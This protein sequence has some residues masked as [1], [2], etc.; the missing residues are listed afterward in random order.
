MEGATR[1]A[2]YK[3]LFLKFRNEIFAIFTGKYLCWSPFNEVAGLQAYN[4]IKK[5]L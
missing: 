1:D 4:S 5:K 2:V 3:K